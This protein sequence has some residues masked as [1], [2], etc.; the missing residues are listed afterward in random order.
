MGSSGV[1][2]S[3]TILSSLGDL[4]EDW[5]LDDLGG[6]IQRYFDFLEDHGGFMLVWLQAARSDE[7]LRKLG[8]RGS[9]HAASLASEAMRK[10]GA[11][12]DEDPHV[13]GL[14]LMALLDRFWYH[15]RI[16]KAPLQASAVTH[17]LA[18]MIAAMLRAD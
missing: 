16:T 10:L 1:A 4:P 8:M 17:G 2:T 11:P 18:R 7:K 15:W 6:W 14:A 12:R 3:Y 5:D 9:M 13:Q